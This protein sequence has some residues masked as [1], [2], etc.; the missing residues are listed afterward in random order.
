MAGLHIIHKPTTANCFVGMVGGGGWGGR[1]EVRLQLLFTPIGQ[2]V[3]SNF[4]A[5]GNTFT[6]GRRKTITGV[7]NVP[8]GVPHLTVNTPRTAVAQPHLAFKC[9]NSVQ[10]LFIYAGSFNRITNTISSWWT[11]SFRIRLLYWVYWLPTLHKCLI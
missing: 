1:Q 4:D 2:K 6:K 9:L 11:R 8:L 3:Q 5:H 10:N 7:H